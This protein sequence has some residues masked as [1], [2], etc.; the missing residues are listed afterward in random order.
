MVYVRARPN[1]AR[2]YGSANVE[3]VFIFSLLRALVADDNAEIFRHV[4]REISA[5]EGEERLN[6]MG[7]MRSKMTKLY[8]F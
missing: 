1:E 2:Q 6:R 7:A 8:K 5:R 3:L 4:D